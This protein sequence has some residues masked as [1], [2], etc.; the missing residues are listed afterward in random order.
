MVEARKPGYLFDGFL[1]HNVL[2]NESNAEFDNENKVNSQLMFKKNRSQLI[3]LNFI[4]LTNYNANCLTSCW[5]IIIKKSPLF[6]MLLTIYLKY[7]LVI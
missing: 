3:R 4:D 2:Q 1:P 7:F 5:L 6:S